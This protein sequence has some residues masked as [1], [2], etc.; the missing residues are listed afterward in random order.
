[1]RRVATARLIAAAFIFHAAPAAAE[2][3][4]LDLEA[5]LAR[6][7]DG[8]PAAVAARGRV[9]EAEATRVGANLRFTDNP[10]IELEAGPRFGG[11]VTP[12][13][14]IQ[15]GQTFALGG[16]RGAR[17]A[18]AD[19]QVAHA[20]ASAAAT[21]LEVRLAVALAI[22][23]ALHAQRVV[24]VT[25][26]GEDLA[27]RAAEVATRRRSA[28]DITDLDAGLARAAA[29]RARAAVSAAEADLAEAI[30]RLAALLALAPDDTL[31]LQGELRPTE[32]L[33]LAAL[34][35]TDRAD[36]QALHAE[37][38]VADAE[39]ALARANGRP[40][41]GLWIAYQREED[42]NIVVGG[43]RLA[44]PLWDRGQGGVAEARARSSRVDAEYT[45]GRRVASR[46]VRDA[47]AV[48]EH[49]RAAVEVFEADVLPVLDDSEDLIGKSV[50][51]GTIAI[52]DYLLAR[53]EL[54]DG[55][56]DYLDLLLALAQ[57]RVTAQLTAGVSP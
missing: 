5:A 14:S 25:E 22:F 35:A 56:K 42:A 15:V 26:A 13:I 29:G 52:S 47:F 11:D 54:L 44:W 21:G 4:V 18:L 37:A 39:A 34:G 3:V 38:D 6:A 20:E 48:Y 28:G 40:E 7:S 32:P 31:V 43:I 24:A 50:D 1:M 49:A 45:V 8:A 23:D 10:E 2:E 55:R 30:G 17:R 9:G 33:T 12:D 27:T 46:Q 41:L 36:L 16:R 53:Q 51:A 57:A 19:A